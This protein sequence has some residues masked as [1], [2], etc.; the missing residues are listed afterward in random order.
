L[1]ACR[2]KIVTPG[3]HIRV[4]DPVQPGRNCLAGCQ[5]LL[6]DMTHLSAP[7][8]GGYNRSE[9]AAPERDCTGQCIS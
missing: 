7:L 4:A 6:N 1:L 8:T 5:K 3:L 2:S 9:A